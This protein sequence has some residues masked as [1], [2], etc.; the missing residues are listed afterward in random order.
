MSFYQESLSNIKVYKTN[1]TKPSQAKAILDKIRLNVPGSDPSFDL[2]DCDKV[3]R[4]E[5]QK[6]PVNDLEIR[7][8]IKASG[9]QIEEL[10]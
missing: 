9:F 10:L 8:L 7:G 4:V 1:V 2:D 5:T 6:E 3:L